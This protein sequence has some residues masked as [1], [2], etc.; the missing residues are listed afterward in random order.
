MRKVETTIYDYNDMTAL[1]EMTP[2]EV[3]EI[4]RYA[5]RGY[6]NKYVYPRPEKDEYSETE[7]YNYAMQC[8]FSLAYEYL[9]RVKEDD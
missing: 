9:E 5:Y 8:A 7:C 3:I 6:I 2:K 1:E 4:L